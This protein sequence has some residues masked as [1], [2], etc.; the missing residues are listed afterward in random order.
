MTCLTC[1]CGL[2]K[3][4]EP[5]RSPIRIKNKITTFGVVDIW[6]NMTVQDLAGTL[7]KDLGECGDDSVV[8]CS[9][10]SL[11][12][13]YTPLLCFPEHIQEVMLYIKG[14][15]NLEP[16]AI[17]ADMK[18]IREIA[19][20]CGHKTKIIAA[21]TTPAAAALLADAEQRDRDAHAREP[22]PDASAL[23][24]P[25]PAVVTVM[26]HVDHGKTTL[27]DSLRGASIAAGEAGGITQHI[28]AFTLRLAGGDG[29]ADAAGERLTVLDTPG[30]AAFSAMRSR[31]A[32]CTD[33]IVLVVAADDGVMP[34]TREV[35]RLA[36]EAAVPIIV[37]VNKVD[38]PGADVERACDE[39]Q[40]CG[41]Q[42]E[43]RGGDVQSVGVSALHGT[44]LPE[45]AECVLA[46]AAVMRLRADRT[47]PVEAVVV[48]ARTDKLRGK[49]ATVIVSRG[50]LRRGAVL[51]CGTAW[52][53]VRGLFDDAGRPVAEARP[54]EPVEVLGWRDELP[55]AGDEVLEVET[56]RRA[57]AV[58]RFREARA[59]EERSGELAAAIRCK[60]EAHEAE[61]RTQRE[62]RRAAGG[63]RLR[64]AERPKETA[65]DDGRPRVSVVLKADVWG[66]V[67]AILDV[68]ETYDEAHQ[69]Q[70]RLDVVHYG[71]GDVNEGDVERARMFGAIV[72]AFGVRAQPEPE[73][74]V[75]EFDVIYR[76]V[77]DLRAEIER[78]LPSVEVD[79]VLG[80]AN[81]LQIFEVTEGRK[82]VQVLGCR[83]VKGVLKKAGKWR[84][85]RQGD[86]VF[87]GGLQSMRHLKS[88]VDSVKSGVE[89]GL[90]LQADGDEVVPQNGDTLVC[91]MSRMV[92]QKTDWD[93]GF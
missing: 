42:L 36:A 68:L 47:G 33:I 27:L 60:E 92:E 22:L 24:L 80:E 79:D 16:D 45:L 15:D 18:I 43:C 21:P 72:Y 44:G 1:A 81:V 84:L 11:H 51:V 77:E 19:L 65:P 30:H 3:A 2:Q 88:E 89:C 31:G 6:R 29:G 64:L 63:R 52:A 54:G 61:Y 62:R 91:F 70:C 82:Q 39:L 74:Q 26:G 17:L 25:R 66:T 38:K 8:N 34:Q 23:L 41:V 53:K 12:F 83:C 10:E 87:A 40:A 71:V 75:R 5:I 56:E 28:G 90:R 57:H 46:Q 85:M 76:L 37:A 49:L 67:E 78:R 48:E 20:K 59:Q 35:L 86:V 69:E 93:P 14:A 50:T 7:N 55:C 73:V 4:P 58:R 9:R 32:N 13:K